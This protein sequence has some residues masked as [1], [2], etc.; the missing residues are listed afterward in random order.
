MPSISSK[1]VLNSAAS[2]SGLAI[3]DIDLI[4]GAFYTV[5]EYDMLDDIPTNRLSDGQIVWVEDASSCYQLTITAANPPITFAPTYTW[6]EFSG[7]GGGSGGGSGDITAVIAGDGIDGGAFSGTAT[8]NLDTGSAHFTNGV[9]DLALFQETGSV[10]TAHSS[11]GVTGSLTIQKDDSGDALSIY[12]GSV[13][14][15][16]I[17]GD[18]LL[19]MVTQSVQPTATPGA[20][21]LEENYNLFIGSE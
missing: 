10:F 3:A 4:K 12:S 20:L 13:K 6:S 7:F 11:I 15:F 8:V 17:T 19:K 16:G 9:L 1:I 14:T 18:G 5:A 21:Y 2:G